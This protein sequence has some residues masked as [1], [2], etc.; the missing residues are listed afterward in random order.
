MSEGVSKSERV[1][2]RV[3]PGLLAD[4]RRAAQLQGQDLTSFVM[5]AAAERAREVLF[6]DSVLR[7]SPAAVLQLEDMFGREPQAI[8]QLA[9]MFERHSPAATRG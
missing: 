9:R 4:V 7:L 2:F 1:Q 6:E 5:G 8:S 3:E